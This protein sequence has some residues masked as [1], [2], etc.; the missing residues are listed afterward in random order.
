MTLT[1]VAAKRMGSHALP[2]VN[3]E[4]ALTLLL[5]LSPMPHQCQRH[6]WAWLKLQS[7]S[8]SVT[9]ELVSN[10][11]KVKTLPT[12]SVERL[13]TLLT[14]AQTQKGNSSRLHIMCE[15]NFS[16]HS[17]PYSTFNYGI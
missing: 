5:L 1:G 16:D 3:A 4:T 14:V 11:K 7:A 9:V 2:A 15:E 17:I 6:K 13:K 8:N 12:G 10:L